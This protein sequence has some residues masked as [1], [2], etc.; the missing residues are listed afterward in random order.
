VASIAEITAERS[1][2]SSRVLTPSI[3]VPAG[4]QTSSLRT[5]GCLPVSRTILAAPSMDWAASIM[6]ASLESPFRTPASAM[7]SITMYMKAGELPAMPVIASIWDSGTSAT[8]P[9]DSRMSATFSFSAGDIFASQVYPMAPSRTMQQWLGMTLTILASGTYPESFSMVSPATMLM[10]ILPSPIFK[11]SS[12]K[13]PATCLG[14]TAMT[15]MSQL[16]HISLARSYISMPYLDDILALVD[17]LGAQATMSSLE[18]TPFESSPPTR[19]SAILPA[20]MK[21][22][23]ARMPGSSYSG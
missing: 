15:T 18:N 20:P 9:T 4:E 3:V 17:S 23:A 6:D 10:T 21:P 13:R 8:S 11:F 1:L 14:L 16:S 19:A 7:A 22:I 12:S 5:S 2:R